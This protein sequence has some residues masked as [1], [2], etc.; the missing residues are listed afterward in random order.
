MIHAPLAEVRSRAQV[1]AEALVKQDAGL[2]VEVRESDA[3]VGGGAAPTVGLPSAVVALAHR[4]VGPDRLAALLRGGTHPVIARVAEDQLLVDLRT[5]RP[6]EEA[7]LLQAITA[8]ARGAS[9]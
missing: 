6:E 8:A 4:R 7:T 9:A 2:A 1:F 3:A 5:V